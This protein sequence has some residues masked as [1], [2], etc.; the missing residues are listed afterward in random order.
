MALRW[1]IAILISMAIAISYLD[2]QTLPVAIKA[3]SKDI[4]LKAAR[5]DAED[6]CSGY[7]SV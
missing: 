7:R 3:I 1:R 2:R 5:A 4:P 6:R